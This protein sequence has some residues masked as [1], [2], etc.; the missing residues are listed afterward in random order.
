MQ[1]MQLLS[2]AGAPTGVTVLVLPGLV[3][4]SYLSR[5]SRIISVEKNMSHGEISVFYTEI[6]Q[7]MEFYLRGEKS[8]V[9]SLH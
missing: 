1:L 6:E 7:F 8:P 3:Q 2:T 5:I 9:E 4:S